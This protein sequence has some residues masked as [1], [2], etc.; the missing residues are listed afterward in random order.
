VGV[1][2]VAGHNLL[3]S[4]HPAS[5]VSGNS[6][7]NSAGTF[8][9]SLLHQEGDFTF[10]PISIFVRYP[11]MPWIGVLAIGYYIGVL[12]TP[13]YS[14]ANRTP[15]LVLL[16]L[17]SISMFILLRSLNWYGDPSHWM[18]ER[19]FLFDLLSFLNTTKYP[20][21]LLY[22]LMTLGPALL[23][24]ALADHHFDFGTWG[25]RVREMVAV[26]G[27]TPMFYYIAHIF[28]VHALAVLGAVVSGYSWTDMMGLTNRVNRVA[29]LKGYGFGLPSVYLVWIAV[30]C[31]LYPV[32]RWFDTYKRSR[33]AQSWWLR[34]L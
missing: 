30:V 4:L 20:P 31:I 2:L 23:F 16:G 1:A 22:L 27:R 29:W 33:Q 9:W 28:L 34:Y 25:R 3:D 6:H 24:L 8:I 26:F 5:L 32:C 18:V 13:V 12:Y 17:G 19:N 11:V 15:T 21:S 14:A 10:G 7:P